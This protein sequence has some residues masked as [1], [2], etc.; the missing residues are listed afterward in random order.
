M[1]LSFFSS[2]FFMFFS[3]PL[4][5]GAVTPRQW[6]GSWRLATPQ[7]STSLG[8][9]PMAAM[10]L[11]ICLV[12]FLKNREKMMDNQ[13]KHHR[14]KWWIIIC[15]V[16]QKKWWIKNDK[17][18]QAMFHDTAGYR[19]DSSSCHRSGSNNMECR[20]NR[21]IRI[22]LASRNLETSL[23]TYSHGKDSCQF[24]DTLDGDSLLVKPFGD[25]I[26]RK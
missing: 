14:K 3:A 16:Y 20:Q 2:V 8:N 1:N 17:Q 22:N 12:F 23:K 10:E 7:G 5:L 4:L 13:K 18:Q 15:V 21:V 6:N 9:P 11:L 26:L 24:S 19:N 25:A